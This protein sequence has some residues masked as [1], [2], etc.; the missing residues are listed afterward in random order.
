VSPEHFDSAGRL[1]L[2]VK[3]VSIGVETLSRQVYCFVW[4]YHGQLE[5]RL[6]YNE[7]FYSVDRMELMVGN[8]RK[9]LFKKLLK[10]SVIL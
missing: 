1:V 9:V 6:V 10:R 5:L 4:L 7:A 8:L 2:K 3:D